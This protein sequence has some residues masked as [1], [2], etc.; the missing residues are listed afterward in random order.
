[1]FV[2]RFLEGDYVILLLY[3]D[4]VLIVGSNVKKIRV[5]KKELAS[6]F[7]SK[8]I[9]AARQI[10][11]MHITRDQKIGSHGYLKRNILR[12]YSSDSV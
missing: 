7:A 11:G 6:A 8:D 9:G 12:R 4:C 1:V 10:L 2:K 5:L 3:V